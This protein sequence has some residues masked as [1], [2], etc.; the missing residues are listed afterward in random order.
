[1]ANGV[2]GEVLTAPYCPAPG[3]RQ[4][5]VHYLIHILC[6]KE[7]PGSWVGQVGK[8]SACSVKNPWFE[9]FPKMTE[10]VVN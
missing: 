2:L 5:R 1:M 4:T 6:I 8:A 9:N 3:H 7:Q 10:D